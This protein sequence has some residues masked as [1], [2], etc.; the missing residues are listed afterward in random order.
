MVIN[1]GDL[2]F[3]TRIYKELEMSNL[4]LDLWPGYRFDQLVRQED[5]KLCWAAATQMV[6]NLKGQKKFTQDDVVNRQLQIEGKS[7][8]C[9]FDDLSRR[10]ECNMEGD[11]SIGDFG[12]SFSHTTAHQ[13]PFPDMCRVLL[14]EENGPIVFKIDR[15]DYTA[16]PD[17]FYLCLGFIYQ[18]NI[19]LLLFFDSKCGGNLG[20]MPYA[21]YKDL[22]DNFKHKKSYFGVQYSNDRSVNIK[23]S[24][25]ISTPGNPLLFDTKYDAVRFWQKVLLDITFEDKQV[26]EGLGIRQPS[27]LREDDMVEISRLNIDRRRVEIP[28]KFLFPIGTEKRI[29]SSIVIC[30]I[31]SKYRLMKMGAPAYTQCVMTGAKRLNHGTPRELLEA[32]DEGTLFRKGKKP[33]KWIPVVKTEVGFKRNR[34]YS[35]DEIVTQIK[36]HYNASK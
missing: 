12:F 7:L 29:E 17:H 15:N 9:S 26:H 8:R 5:S 28:R 6:M 2:I 24:P 25:Q 13:I 21:T 18:D 22:P 36:N 1:R 3:E 11:L 27:I 4:T 14:S 31:Q 16:G 35:I 19:R 20:L 32:G 10:K 33:G 30:H 23:A 34:G